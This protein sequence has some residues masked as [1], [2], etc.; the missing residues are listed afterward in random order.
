M[1]YVTMKTC[2]SCTSGGIYGGNLTDTSIKTF[3]RH[4]WWQ[5]GRDVNQTHSGGIYGSN[6]TDMSIKQSPENSPEIFSKSDCNKSV[7]V[8]ERTEFTYIA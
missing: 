2:Q 1:K 7:K 5:F 8:S 6:L 4:L 3:W